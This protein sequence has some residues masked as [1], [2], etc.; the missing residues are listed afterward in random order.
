MELTNESN[1]PSYVL[2]SDFQT[3]KDK[4]DS[5]KLKYKNLQ[6]E[7]T[8]L[9]TMMDS[10][11]EN[12]QITE[13]TQHKVKQIAQNIQNSLTTFKN[14]LCI[15]SDSMQVIAD[16]SNKTKSFKYIS[17]PDSFSTYANT[18]SKD[19]N[20]KRVED[21]ESAFVTMNRNF[22]LMV[23]KFKI[24]R[25]ENVKFLNGNLKLLEA[26]E[27]MKNENNSLNNKCRELEEAVRHYKEVEKCLVEACVNS[28]VL[29][30]TEDK[31]QTTTIACEPVSSFVKF[32]R[33]KD[34]T[35]LNLN[36]NC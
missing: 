2:Y 10:M 20:A 28:A 13:M 18:V 9:Q 14:N 24:L 23:L 17:R 8:S 16:S 21:I 6:K 4:Y 1:E 19:Q 25:E 35:H 12:I 15:T 26:V 34:N 29:N 3:F 30:S 27:T 11:I 36:L 5:L 7:K 31:G 22:Q 33:R 32:L